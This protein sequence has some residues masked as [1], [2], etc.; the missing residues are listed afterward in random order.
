MIRQIGRLEDV[1]TDNR[2]VR[3]KNQCRISKAGTP[4]GMDEHS[5]DVAGKPAAFE[6]VELMMVEATRR[7]APVRHQAMEGPC[8]H[9]IRRLAGAGR[10]PSCV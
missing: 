5:V 10:R 9:Q 8:S 2:A 4:A 1:N 6:A 7:K 3:I